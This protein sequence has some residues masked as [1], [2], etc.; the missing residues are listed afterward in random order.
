M[1]EFSLWFFVLVA[2]FLI[3]FFVLNAI[4]FKPLAKVLEDREGAI[5]GALNEAKAMTISKEE[6]IARFN[7]ELLS[8]KNRAKEIFD[9]L[10]EE[11]LARQKEVLSKTEAEAVDMIE[12]ARKELYTET[13]KAKTELKAGIE[14]LSEEI[15]GKLVKT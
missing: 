8:T 1:I 9:L 15:V 6:S 4:L 14:R 13:E 2:N 12:K 3:L 11:G 7:S 10:K 5:D